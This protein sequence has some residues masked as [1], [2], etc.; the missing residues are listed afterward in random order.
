MRDQFNKKKKKQLYNP[1]A[2]LL[3]SHKYVF[4]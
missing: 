2:T 1:P 3:L 4:K